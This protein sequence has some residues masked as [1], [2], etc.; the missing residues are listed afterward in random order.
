MLSVQNLSFSFGH[1][2]IFDEVSFSI[3]RGQKVGIVGPNGAGKSTLLSLITQKSETD[4]GHIKILG[5]IASVPQE[6]KND[7]VLDEAESV[8]NYLDPERVHQDFELKNMLSGLEMG[9][10]ELTGNPKDFSGGQ[11]TRLAIIRAIL[12]KPDLLLLDEPTNFLDTKGKAWVMD[13]LGNFENAVIIISHDLDLLDAHI[14]KVLYLNTHTKKVDEYKG[15]YTQFL[16]LKTENEK[17][18]KKQIKAGTQ[19]IESMEEG[20]RMKTQS[21]RQRIQLQMR[22]EKEKEK[23]PDMPPE[24]KS[25]GNFN[26]PEPTRSGEIPIKAINISKSYGEHKVLENVSFYLLRGERLALLGQNGAGKSTLLKIL[27]GATEK[28]SGEVIK[29][30]K[31]KL[32]YYS[33]EHEVLDYSKTLFDTVQQTAHLSDSQT[34]SVLGKFM[35]RDKKVFQTVGSLSGG[36]KTRLA[37]ALLVLQDYN[38]LILDEPTT[39]L[40]VLSQRVILEALKNY[41]GAMIIVSHTEEFIDE[42]KPDRVLLL[43]ENKIDTWHDHYLTKVSEI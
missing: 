16:K 5:T 17:L 22:I 15:N 25:L 28:N 23:L 27:I 3:A 35:F 41:K 11:K 38:L 1:H 7:P 9:H 2:I 6:V 12:V 37:I 10:M 33:Q 43:P 18:L 24:I 32:G 30:E 20:L 4:L 36:E 21:V 34:R 40:D 14:H 29:D 13:F 8:R 26:L 19:H 42:L 31:L 39:Y